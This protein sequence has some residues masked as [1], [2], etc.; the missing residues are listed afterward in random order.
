MY[1]NVTWLYL[2]SFV[3]FALFIQISNQSEPERIADEKGNK[4]DKTPK[5]ECKWH[6]DKAKPPPK[7]TKK[8]YSKDLV[9]EWFEGDEVLEKL[10]KMLQ[11]GD[12]I[13]EKVSWDVNHWMLYIG[14]VEDELAK[15]NDKP[16]D[17]SVKKEER[18]KHMYIHFTHPDG[19]LGCRIKFSVRKRNC[20]HFV[21]TIKHGVPFSPIADGYSCF[22]MDQWRNQAYS[23]LPGIDDYKELYSI[24]DA[25]QNSVF[26]QV[27]GASWVNVIEDYMP[28][29]VIDTKANTVDF[30]VVPP[31]SW[32]LNMDVLNFIHE[33]IKKVWTVKLTGARRTMKEPALRNALNALTVL[34]WNF[35][36]QQVYNMVKRAFELQSA[37]LQPLKNTY[38]H[39][40]FDN[41]ETFVKA[42]NECYNYWNISG[43]DQ[44]LQQV[45]EN[46]VGKSQSKSLKYP[47]TG[48]QYIL[49]HKQGVAEENKSTTKREN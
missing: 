30:S 32:D 41:S 8:P 6:L 49:T 35:L 44:K 18:N 45:L 17:D 15:K 7:E 43:V 38:P 16:F 25:P 3:C 19:D 21:F 2:Y 37:S 4:D 26:I 27:Y 14:T 10:V 31:D 47:L 33:K 11:P 12:L 34:E 29:L 24:K 39:V 20:Q 9:S 46:L 40:I 48:M 28:T 42:H 23:I 36:I 1:K 5:A 13:E 22:K